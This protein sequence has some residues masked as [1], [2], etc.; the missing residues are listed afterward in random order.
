MWNIATNYLAYCKPD[1]VLSFI[2]LAKL[3]NLSHFANFL[4]E[5]RVVNSSKYNLSHYFVNGRPHFYSFPIRSSELLQILS[6]QR[7]SL[8]NNK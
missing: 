4:Q 6:R 3:M 1:T 8:R 2:S 7:P 5:N